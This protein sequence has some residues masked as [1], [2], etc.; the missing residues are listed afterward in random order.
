MLSLAAFGVYI[1][2]FFC[3]K[4]CLNLPQNSPQHLDSVRLIV[5]I[6][7]TERRLSL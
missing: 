1:T 2:I 6:S 5:H 7:Q 3:S 4:T